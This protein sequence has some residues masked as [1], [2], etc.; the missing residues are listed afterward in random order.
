MDDFP[1]FMKHSANKG[2]V[3]KLR[4]SMP[5][6]HPA[7]GRAFVARFGEHYSES[8]GSRMGANERLMGRG[9]RPYTTLSV[10]TGINESTARVTALSIR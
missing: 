10:E 7:D 2:S 8:R 6:V 3:E 5:H 9:A 1:D 4:F